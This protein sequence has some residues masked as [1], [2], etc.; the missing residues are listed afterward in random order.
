MNITIF[1]CGH[2]GLIY[3]R[4]F[5]KNNLAEEHQIVLV[6]K[7][8]TRRELLSTMNVGRVVLPGDQILQETDILFLAVKPQDFPAAA[9]HLALSPLPE[10]AII[11]SIM[12]GVTIDTIIDLTHHRGV[13]RAMPNA[14]VAVEKGITAFYPSSAISPD[15]IITAHRL[16]STTGDVVK[17]ENEA[18]LDIVTAISGSG[19]AYFFYLAAAMREAGIKLGL[20]EELAETLVKKT[21][22]GSYY[23]MQHLNQPTDKLISI[24]ASK[25]GTT[26]AA[27]RVFDEGRVNEHLQQ[28][29]IAAANRSAELSQLAAVK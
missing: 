16:L 10:Q 22:Q 21:M 26:E 6:E 25:G 18:H 4:L 11:I 15:Q 19:P 2:M 12:A 24:I 29:V 5:I 13:I 7:D 1:G 8:A 27:L 23:F 20:D 14:A 9:A 17:L 3:A 28:G